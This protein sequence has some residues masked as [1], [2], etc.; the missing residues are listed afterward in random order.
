MNKILIVGATSA[1]AEHCAR[2]WA[3][4]G[5]SIFL[6]GR[7]KKKLNIIESDLKVR[8]SKN[9]SSIILKIIIK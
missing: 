6:V 9:V 5:D 2:I 8:G 7:N 3:S 4:K 1:I